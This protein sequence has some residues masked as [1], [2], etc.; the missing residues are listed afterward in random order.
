LIHAYIVTYGSDRSAPHSWRHDRKLAI[1]S[2]GAKQPAPD[3][4]L[5]VPLPQRSPLYQ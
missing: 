1:G 5:A 3:P 2:G 4:P